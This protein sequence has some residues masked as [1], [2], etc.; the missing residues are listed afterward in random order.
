MQLQTLV[1]QFKDQEPPA[2]ARLRYYFACDYPLRY[3]QHFEMGEMWMRLGCAASALEMFQKVEMHEEAIECLLITEQ[4]N[5]AKELALQRLEVAPTARLLCTLGDITGEEEY[6]QRAWE[7]SHT[8]SRAQRTLARRAFE[9][10]D[11]TTCVDH[12]TLALE[13][14]PL[15]H[16]AWF[17]KGCALMRLQRWADGAHA[18]VQMVSL[19]D[20]QA[21]AWNNL[22]ACRIHEGKPQEAFLAL[23]QG[24]KHS[25]RNWKMWE[26]MLQ[27]G[28]SLKRP[29]AVLEAFQTL[30]ELKHFE[31][32][33]D[34]VFRV[35]WV[36]GAKEGKFAKVV[37]L[38][39][40]YSNSTSPGPF[41]WK[42]YADLLCA[43]QKP[44]E[45]AE[46]VQLRIKACRALMK[47]GWDSDPEACEQLIVF[48]CEVANAYA[49]IMDEP[50]KIEGRLFVQQVKEGI[51]KALRREITVPQ[52]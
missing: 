15:F 29:P 17:T 24:L 32:L 34:P 43:A 45:Q 5:K 9:R 20:S 8:C 40:Q 16:S 52:F 3:W 12:Y 46:V 1:D 31:C 25:R 39:L 10:Q 33:Q 22:A 19:D 11:F 2:A 35:M 49:L 28:I 48:L 27:L 41:F 50:A 47:V 13:V 51:Q 44:L 37:E 18:F 14:N 6:Y 21:D 38:F 4:P 23:E 7:M 36:I 42:V 26:N 30:V